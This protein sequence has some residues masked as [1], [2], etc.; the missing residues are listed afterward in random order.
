[1]AWN[2]RAAEPRSVTVHCTLPLFDYLHHKHHSVL[3]YLIISEGDKKC[4]VTKVDNY[5]DQ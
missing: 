1:M 2:R 5:N 3:Y 4:T